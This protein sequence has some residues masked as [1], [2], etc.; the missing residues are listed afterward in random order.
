VRR[1]CHSE[2]SPQRGYNT[3]D[4]FGEGFDLRSSLIV[5]L[6]FT[7]SI[8]LIQA[9][10]KLPKCQD[11]PTWIDPPWVNGLEWCLELVLKDDSA[12]ELGYTALAAAPDGTLYA[13]R[14][15]TGEVLVL[16]DEDGDDLPE[17]PRVVGDDLTLPNGL[18]FYEGTLYISGAQHIYRMDGDF[19][20]ETLVDDLPWGAGFWT[21]G[22]TIGPDE[23]I[24]VAIGATC[25]YCE[26]TDTTRSSIWSYALDGSDPRQIASGLRQPGDVAFRDGVLWTLD[27]ARDGLDA[28]DLDEINRV[29]EGMHFG[30]PYC[31]GADN[32]PDTLVGT[33]DCT[34]AAK[35]MLVMPTHSTPIR[36]ETYNSDALSSIENNLLV[37]LHGSYNQ[38]DLQGYALAVVQF[39]DEDQ[40]SGYRVIIP[41]QVIY[42][43]QLSRY[44]YPL[45]E[46]QYQ[47]SGFWPH[48]PLDVA[49]S[50]EGW[51]YI[52]VGGGQIFALRPLA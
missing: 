2:E 43:Q 37:V 11:R 30:W 20:V 6:F 40:I 19:H 52:S 4:N 46:I 16:T 33:F 48:R 23:R 15:N 39:D 21:G 41:E 1:S 22:L 35:P 47:E 29:T 28:P 7:L 5:I 10:D 8:G 42:P 3:G 26:Q 45:A 13:T 34:Q 44:I 38:S 50:R 12:G 36:L 18:A 32:Q 25:D 27:S 31:F 49:V 9:Q 51:I 17:T 14:P 24:Y